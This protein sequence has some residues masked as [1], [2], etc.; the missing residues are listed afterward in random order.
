LRLS[1]EKRLTLKFQTAILCAMS[2]VAEIKQ[3]VA[4]GIG[5]RIE[6][7]RQTQIS[8]HDQIHSTLRS[9]DRQTP[10]RNMEV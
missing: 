3:A 2:T 1:L 6:T 4:R 7:D 9:A 10:S 5:W 8:N